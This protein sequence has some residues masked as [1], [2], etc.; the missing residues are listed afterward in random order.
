MN[1]RAGQLAS[2]PPRTAIA[3]LAGA[4]QR[5]LKLLFDP[6]KLVYISGE[7]TFLIRN[8][9]SNKTLSI[10]TRDNYTYDVVNEIESK[11]NNKQLCEKKNPDNQTCFIIVNPESGKVLTVTFEGLKAKGN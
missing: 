1:L 7:T 2:Q 8:L 10:M 4:P 6:L 3:V 5:S 11:T 9:S